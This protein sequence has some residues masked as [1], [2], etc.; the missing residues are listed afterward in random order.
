MLKE[1][2]FAFK[3]IKQ[4]QSL[5]SFGKINSKFLLPKPPVSEH[6]PRPTTKPHLPLDSTNTFP[7]D[8]Q[9]IQQTTNEPT[10]SAQL[11][12]LNHSLPENLPDS[13]TNQETP[14]ENPIV[15]SSNTNISAQSTRNTELRG[16][17]AH[18]FALTLKNTN[19]RLERAQN[20]VA[21]REFSSNQTI[22]NPFLNINSQESKPDKANLNKRKQDFQSS[23]DTIKRI[24][25]IRKR[26]NQTLAMNHNVLNQNS[27]T[28]FKAQAARRRSTF[29]L[30][31]KR[32]SGI[33]SGYSA[34]PHEEIQTMYL[35]KHISPEAPEPVR[36]R[37]LLSW[38]VQRAPKPK[39]PAVFQENNAVSS[40][41]K[42]ALDEIIYEVQAAIEGGVMTTSWYNRNKSSSELVNER[43]NKKKPH[44]NNTT[45][46]KRRTE[47][48]EVLVKLQE[49]ERGLQTVEY[50]AKEMLSNIKS[51]LPSQLKDS[52]N[53][54]LDNIPVDNQQIQLMNNNRELQNVI[55]WNLSDQINK[56]RVSTEH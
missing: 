35:Y 8:S 29:G 30:R 31:G 5:R 9:E 19:V 28:S 34:C 18:A 22:N 7:N 10:P 36:L 17:I 13:N 23:S 54:K 27:K 25:S 37:Q 55:E 38:C 40:I 53:P 11:K 33:G 51:L 47:L 43:I 32:A 44:P 52:E 20:A 42:K 6:P 15:E 16:K 4:S 21:K 45:N 48:I 24:K 39:A 2:R 46:E 50:K 1:P 49:E 41:Y 12:V 3:Q 56:C 14:S 26:K